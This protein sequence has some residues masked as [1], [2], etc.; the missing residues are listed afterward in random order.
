MGEEVVRDVVMRNLHEKP[1][2]NLISEDG[3]DAALR[4]GRRS[5]RSSRA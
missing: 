3:G 4:C 2:V 5:G 1:S